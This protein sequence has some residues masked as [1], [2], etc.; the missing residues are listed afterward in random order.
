MSPIARA[1][2]TRRLATIAQ[3]STLGAPVILTTGTGR[4]EGYIT[5][6]DDTHIRIQDPI[7]GTAA[8][9]ALADLVDVSTYNA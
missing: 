2:H 5:A 7:R 3:L 4:A 1:A 6:Q 8:V 9:L